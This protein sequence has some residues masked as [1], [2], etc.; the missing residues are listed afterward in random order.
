MFEASREMRPLGVGLNLQPNAVRELCDLGISA[1]E[2]NQVG[3]PVKE[4]A[5]VELNGKEVCSEPRGRHAGYNW[6][7]Y[8]VHRGEFHILL[9]ENVVERIGSSAVELGTRVTGYTQ[10]EA[11]VE[12]RLCRYDGT[13]DTAEGNILIG[14]D[15]IHSATRVQMHPDQ[16]PIHWGGVVM[17]RVLR[18]PSRC[19][20]SRLLQVSAR[21]GIEWWFI[22]F[23]TRVPTEQR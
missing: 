20:P 23:P 12:V 15:G 4:W 13:K 11:G 9:Y 3:V 14:A 22:L 17:W 21:I 16:P 8:V 2:L 19:A 18:K 7:Q 5:L 6:P 10:D 1:C